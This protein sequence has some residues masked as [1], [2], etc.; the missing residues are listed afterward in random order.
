MSNWTLC[1]TLV[2]ITI[3][4][5][6]MNINVTKG[7]GTGPTELSAFDQALVSA[8]VANFNLI[9]LSSVLPPNS[10]VIT[11]DTLPEVE[12]EWGDRLYIVMAQMRVSQRNHEAWAGVGW[13]QDPATK[14]GLLV[15]HEGHSEAEVRADIKNSLEALAKNRGTKFGP[16]SMEVVGIRCELDPVCALVCAVFE[17]ASWKGTKLPS[18]NVS[19]LRRLTGTARK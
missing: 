9:Y 11:H 5:R 12:G 7:T 16:I 10:K 2:V 17:S 13:I 18:K 8:G 1:G 3:K 19:V 6:K 4:T 15:E 14:K